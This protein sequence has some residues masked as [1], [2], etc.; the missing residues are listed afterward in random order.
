MTS[1]NLISVAE[2]A[3]KLGKKPRTL[4]LWRER[5]YG[6]PFKLIG[7]TPWYSPAD[8]DRWIEEQTVNPEAVGQ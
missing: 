6:P 7:R 4:R 3:R 2:A 8:I 1:E 5:G